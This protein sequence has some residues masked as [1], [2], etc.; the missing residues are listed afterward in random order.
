LLPPVDRVTA[1]DQAQSSEI[2]IMKKNRKQPQTASSPSR[3]ASIRQH[4]FAWAC[5]VLLGLAACGGQGPDASADVAASAAASLDDRRASAEAGPEHHTVIAQRLAQAT[6]AGLGRTALQI[7]ASQGHYG[8]ALAEDGWQ[9]RQIGPDE[10]PKSA[11]TVVYVNASDPAVDAKALRQRLAGFVG[12]IIIDS[13]RLIA[14]EPTEGT[15]AEASAEFASADLLEALSGGQAKVVPLATALLVSRSSGRILGIEVSP[16]GLV[17]GADPSERQLATFNPLLALSDNSEQARIAAAEPPRARALAAS[18]SAWDFK[19]DF[20]EVNDGW[21]ASGQVLLNAYRNGDGAVR[22]F[23]QMKVF[24]GSSVQPCTVNGV[25]CGIYPN[26]VDFIVFTPTRTN[27][28]NEQ[29]IKVVASA[30]RYTA[31]AQA[32]PALGIATHSPRNTT[33]DLWTE[34]TDFEADYTGQRLNIRAAIAASGSTHATFGSGI[35]GVHLD[36][37]FRKATDRWWIDSVR[38]WVGPARAK[39]S[40]SFHV[41][42]RNYLDTVVMPEQFLHPSINTPG[43]ALGRHKFRDMVLNG[44]Y[45]SD[46]PW[47]SSYTMHNRD[48]S[49]RRSRLSYEGWNPHIDALFEVNTARILARNGSAFVDVRGGLTYSRPEFTFIRSQTARC[50]NNGDT[51]P[52]RT[53][54]RLDSVQGTTR[55]DGYNTTVPKRWREYDAGVNLRVYHTHFD[56]R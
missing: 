28:Y 49:H 39:A 51:G 40:V 19:V 20:A 36:A 32:Y 1:D 17:N 14:P 44:R 9:F 46:S 42:T 8:R 48:L 43:A 34:D 47:D 15:S 41:K 30:E 18:V 4:T 33:A 55:G 2:L 24:T 6:Q 37:Y 7:G 27:Q 54:Y 26:S 10:L 13:D 5:C 31:Y 16:S 3:T 29:P 38:G 35:Q 56:T 53:G 23:V 22:T 45:C 25:A 12:L 50:E 52:Q 21:N 11:D